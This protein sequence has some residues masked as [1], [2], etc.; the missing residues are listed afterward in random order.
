MARNPVTQI[1]IT[2][3]DEAT[4]VF[5]GLRAHAGKIATAIAGY[6]GIQMFGDALG[7]AREFEAAMS[8]VG[9]AS[10]ATG[11]DLQALRNAADEAGTTTRYTATEAA[12][13]L[14]TLAKS[15]LSA[16]QSVQA[17]P[18]VL[19]LAQ[20]GGVGL[21]EASEFVTKAVNG[22]G[23]EFAEAGRV[24]DVLAAGA[25][26][27]NTSVQGLAGALS[28]AAPVANSLGLS[29]EETVAVIGKFADAGIDASRAGTALNSI[30]SQFSNPASK[31]RQELAAA[32]IT[33]GDFNQALRQLAAAGPEGQRAVLAVGQEAGPALRALLNQG[34]GALDDLTAKLNNAAGSAE[35]TAAVMNNNLDGAVTGLGSAWDALRRALV[36]PLLEPITAE[37][38]KLSTGLRGFVT[39]GTA[40][41]FGD[42]L[43]AAFQSGA[44]WAQDFIAQIDFTALAAKMQ[45]WAAQA[46]DAFAKI[47]E[48]ASTAGATA[49]TAYGVM[50]AG[51]NTVL[52]AVYKLGQGASL[53]ASSFLSDLALITEGLSKI[54]FG[55]LSAGF[56]Q[57]TETMRAEAR[58]TYS[59][60][61]EF[62]RKAD[63]AFAA[64]VQGAETARA[65]FSRFGQSAAESATATAAA[66]E[67]AAGAMTAMAE[68][69]GLTADEFEALGEN[70][71]VTGGKV[72]EASNKSAAAVESFAT[73]S[74]ARIAELRAE[75]ARLIEAGDTQAAA[76]KLIE[77]QQ[78][79][80]RTGRQASVTADE[81][82]QAFKALGVTSQAELDR[83][84]ESAR[85]SF[86]LIRES[87]TAT[88]RE[89]QQAF[90]AYAER[91]IA[92]NDGV[93][94]ASLRAQA[95]MYGVR[96]EA[97]DMGKAVVAAA[98][99]GAA[100]MARL[101]TEAEEVADR[102]GVIRREYEGLK[103]VWDADGNL[104]RQS[105]ERAGGRGSAGGSANIYSTWAQWD[106]ASL[107]RAVAGQ[108]GAA[109]AEA[110][111]EELKRRSNGGSSSP[112][113][114]GARPQS[115][116]AAPRDSSTSHSVS[117]TIGSR[118][119]T[120]N[121]ATR[122]DADALVNL[123]RQLEDAAMRS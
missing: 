109:V 33:T 73:G 77:L 72:V 39:G 2:A 54:T 101:K 60:Y 58:A 85:R 29:L 123:L 86:E 49:Q 63:E 25:N 120:I 24:A 103:G 57:A 23:L 82:E 115:T 30:L 93:A 89:M 92:A 55:N 4:S 100:A 119:Q 14:E 65:G 91:A 59:V 117:I 13:A 114:Q 45:A 48:Y 116:G 66:A 56:A 110:A 80:A 64:A 44:K 50:S 78:E 22:M 97:D 108:F 96:I 118:A 19:N 40:K 71:T 88:P 74:A 84:A 122:Q 70:A 67:K 28:Y 107:R 79:L 121:A 35:A 76:E 69:T 75:Y 26:A 68:Q 20:A 99:A 43:A 102:V 32:G 47:G 31:F 41:A 21:A 52:A 36:D 10:G 5:T 53:L 95:A 105:N 81:V 83:L 61:E 46:G 17:L 7:S 90:A 112:S 94:D 113:L 42:A 1:L 106:D 51:I 27:S 6:F 3:K 16:T 38:N 62:G 15:G 8:R 18:A 11:D 34:M 9:A 104:I 12:N 111:M 98:D 87:G 37:V